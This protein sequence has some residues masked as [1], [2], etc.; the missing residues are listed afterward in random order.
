M[1]PSLQELSTMLR[2][3]VGE[4]TAKKEGVIGITPLYTLER[5]CLVKAHPGKV[6]CL[7]GIVPAS[8]KA[9]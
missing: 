2:R 3:F 9:A 4:V 6:H 5:M 7:F 8:A 1:S